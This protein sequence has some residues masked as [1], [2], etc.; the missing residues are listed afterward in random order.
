MAPPP[1]LCAKTPWC[2]QAVTDAAALPRS[3]LAPSRP[4]IVRFD[5]R[6]WCPDLFGSAIAQGDDAQ[7]VRK[8]LGLPKYQGSPLLAVQ[9]EYCGRHQPAITA[10]PQRRFWPQTGIDL[11]AFLSTGVLLAKMMSLFAWQTWETSFT[12]PVEYKAAGTY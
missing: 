3:G 6:S 7:E 12:S 1:L 9:C 4:T 8:P 2:A 5:K 10:K 11:S